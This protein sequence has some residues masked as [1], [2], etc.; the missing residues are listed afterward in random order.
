MGPDPFA[1]IDRLKALGLFSDAELKEMARAINSQLDDLQGFAFAT[2]TAH[3]YMMNVGGLG[4]LFLALLRT[5][6][7]DITVQ[8]AW[9]LAQTEEGR[10]ALPKATGQDEP[11]NG[12]RPAG[13]A[14]PPAASSGPLS[15]DG[16][17][18]ERAA[19]PSR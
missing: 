12:V 17:S 11:G 16:S 6:H 10:A 7:P 19:S 9:L 14:T 8:Q 1:R 3:R 2:L 5:N 13:A 15:S 18:T 4:H